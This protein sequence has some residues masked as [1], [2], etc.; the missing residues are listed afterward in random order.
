[1]A[2]S[3][4]KPTQH[5]PQELFVDSTSAHT[6]T[7]P[8]IVLSQQQEAQRFYNF[9]F[10]ALPGSG[11]APPFL[12]N[13]LFV[14]DPNYQQ[15]CHQNLPV[16]RMAAQKEVKL[17]LFTGQNTI[18]A[19]HWLNLFEVVCAQ[20]HLIDS[21]DK[22]TK[23]MSY[24][25]D[26]ALA[27]FAQKIAPDISTIT[28][29]DARR[30]IE[31]RFG[32]PDVS[33][34][35]SAKDR[36]LRRSETIKE[37]F[38]SKM[39]LLDKT[40]ITEEE[41]CDLLTDGTPEAYQTHLIPVITTA[42]E[43]WL[44]KALRIEISVNRRHSQHRDSHFR[45][46]SPNKPH[47]TYQLA[48]NISNDGQLT[49]RD[50]RH[51]QSKPAPYPCR[52]CL[53]QGCEEYHW[54]N[55]C[56]LRAKPGQ[57]SGNR[58]SG[59][60]A[61]QHVSRK[62]T[63]DNQSSPSPTSCDSPD[64]LSD[65]SNQSEDNGF[66]ST[67]SIEQSYRF[68]TIDVKLDDVPLQAIVDSGSTISVASEKTFKSLQTQLTPKSSIKVNQINGQTHTIGHFKVNLQMANQSKPITIH[69]IQNFK[70]P[71]LLG[72]DA[73]KL[74]GLTIDLKDGKVSVDTNP[75]ANEYS[76]Q[77]QQPLSQQTAPHKPKS[78]TSPKRTSP[79]I[80]DNPQHKPLPQSLPVVT[81]D[82]GQGQHKGQGRPGSSMCA[83]K[84]D[85]QHNQ[86]PQEPTGPPIKDTGQQANQRTDRHQQQR[87]T[88]HDKEH[89]QLDPKIG[90][91]VER[92]TASNGTKQKDSSPRYSG[93]YSVTRFLGP[94]TVEITDSTSNYS[95]HVDIDQLVVFV[96]REANN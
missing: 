69:V 25:K 1:M 82:D 71:L 63:N 48:S 58:N 80:K 86:S 7:L 34:I 17:E 54:H 3:S 81:I 35:V 42:T 11:A 62:P 21:E 77:P 66:C 55:Q 49:P 40:S 23:L 10:G 51:T 57:Y 83:T 43:D 31:K 50:P 4:F 73:G 18:E 15:A 29:A 76:S 84:S 26:D 68:P 19:K 85:C 41:K 60:R 5:T 12:I 78:S 46:Q 37:Y 52:Y 39:K 8:A 96:P 64:D 88:N 28:W 16:F 61:I 6:S 70:Y 87:I 53:Q 33:S 72:L 90:S 44:Q 9:W 36:R 22:V 47:N 95:L 93:P 32:T 94:D 2:Y 13:Q 14:E 91:K 45:P 24:L 67:P 59:Q 75:S 20:L 38:D 30:L 74:F 89:S 92:N 27:F 65:S 56:P 79:Q